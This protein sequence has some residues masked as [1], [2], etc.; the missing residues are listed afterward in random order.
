MCEQAM[1]HACLFHRDLRIGQR[2][3]LEVV[4][5]VHQWMMVALG[6][7]GPEHVQQDLRILG[8]VLS[9]KLCIASPV[10]STAIHV[11]L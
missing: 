6:K 2:Q 1:Q 9:Q 8:V 5:I 7:P 10:P 11:K 3:L 4:R